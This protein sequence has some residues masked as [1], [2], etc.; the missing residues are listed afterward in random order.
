MSLNKVMLIG[1]L[2]IDPVV[3][4]L[5]NNRVVAQFTL[6]TNEAYLDKNGERK[7]ETEWHNIE[8]WDQVA[9]SVDQLKMKGLLKKG[10]QVYVEGKIRSEL[11][12]DQNGL[13]VMRKKIKANQVQLLG[14]AKPPEKKSNESHTENNNV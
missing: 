10:T 1:N 14:T 4:Y 9:K 11:Y 6:A 3:K 7:V 8:I 12:K 13:E 2:G 5:E